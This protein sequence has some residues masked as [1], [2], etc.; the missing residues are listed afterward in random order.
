MTRE[1]KEMFTVFQREIK[2]VYR[3]NNHRVR[4]AKPMPVAYPLSIGDVE[5][6]PTNWD[7]ETKERLLAS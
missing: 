3:K 7:I 5:Y 2:R 4:Y 1:N 6:Y